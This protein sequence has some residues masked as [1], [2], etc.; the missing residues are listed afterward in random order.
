MPH[1]RRYYAMKASTLIEV[2]SAAHLTRY[3]DS[4]V[5]QQRGGIF[6]IAPP[7]CLKSTII[8]NS[9]QCYPD[10]LRLSDL[11]VKVLSDM[12]GSF[13]EGKY[14][15]MAFGE[16]EKLYQ[17]NPNTAANLEGQLKAMVEE[18]FSKNSFEDARTIT[19]E[20]RVLLIGGITPG[21]YTRL[22]TRWS[23]GGFSRR[24]LWCSYVMDNPNVIADAIDK[25]KSLNFGKST[26]EY[27]N[28][29]IIPYSVNKT[30]SSTIRGM[31]GSQPAV[32]SPFVLMK[33]ILCVL[34]WRHRQ[35]K[36]FEILE[37]FAEALAERPA[38]LVI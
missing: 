37:D 21:C 8:K 9:L 13:I 14:T 10:C 31:L 2:L 36:A 3:V 29:G 4:N 32:D 19:F 1:A 22:Y 6:L 27:P 30:E 15:T 7:G 16:F 25:W 35:K 11:N 5:F 24:F 26:K 18:G 20:S 17:R 23:E 33:K 12:K 28:S 34:K 38:K